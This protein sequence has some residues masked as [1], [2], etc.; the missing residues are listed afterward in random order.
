MLK[1]CTMTFT[2]CMVECGVARKLDHQSSKFV[3]DIMTRY[4]LMHPEMCLVVDEVSS[5]ISQRGDGHIAGMKYCCEYGSIP[6][7]KASHNDRHF[8]LL[9]FTALTGEPVC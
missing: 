8:T 6:N 5:N 2:I 1:K 9:G 4:E 7:N 3:G